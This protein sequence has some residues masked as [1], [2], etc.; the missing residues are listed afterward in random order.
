MSA[1]IT[2]DPS[3]KS[4]VS[5]TPYDLSRAARS[6]GFEDDIEL[7]QEVAR[8]LHAILR[9]RTDNRESLDHVEMRNE[10]IDSIS[11]LWE[12]DPSSNTMWLATISN[13]YNALIRDL[14][15]QVREAR[16]LPR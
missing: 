1:S 13:T 10:W 5:R 16:G 4:D 6:G 12:G 9:R 2:P 15:A 14:S 7:G 11:D 3:G 8:R